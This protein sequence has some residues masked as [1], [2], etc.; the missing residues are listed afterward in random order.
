MAEV[1]P[2]VCSESRGA[3]DGERRRQFAELGPPRGRSSRRS[4]LRERPR[5]GPLGPPG[6]DL[7]R[8]RGDL[9]RAARSRSKG[10]LDLLLSS[11]LGD[12]TLSL[13]SSSLLGENLR[14]LLGRGDLALDRQFMESRGLR[15]LRNG[16][17]LDLRRSP[18]AC[19]TLS[20]RT[21]HPKA[22]FTIRTWMIAVTAW[23]WRSGPV[24]SG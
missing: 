17:V 14:G 6:G 3:E 2:D 18:E 15:S 20:V 8:R 21:F 9:V 19:Q 4:G 22:S 13:L 12:L 7:D 5:Q 11:R 10:D 23:W 16:G 24:S 1:L